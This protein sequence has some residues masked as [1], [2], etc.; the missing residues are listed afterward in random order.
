[1]GHIKLTMKPL[2]L[3]FSITF[4]QGKF[5]N[6]WHYLQSSFVY[7]SL[8]INYEFLKAMITSPY[9]LHS[10]LLFSYV[11]R[12]YPRHVLGLEIVSR[13]AIIGYV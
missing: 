5:S 8:Q 7:K 4:T 10:S 11:V 9:C 3:P 2:V 12:C 6:R 1:M 13:Q